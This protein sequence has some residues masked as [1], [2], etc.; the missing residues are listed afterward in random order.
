[1][2]NN[3]EENIEENLEEIEKQEET[4]EEEILEDI[5]EAEESGELVNSLKD[6]LLRLQAD[7]MNFKRRSEEQ[8]S[9]SMDYAKEKFA[10][11][12]LPCI[13]NFERALES[14]EEDKGSFYDGV[15]MIYEE[16]IKVLKKNNIEE[17]DALGEAFD[18]NMHHAVF[19]EESDNHDPET[20]IEI[21]QKGYKIKEKVIRPAMVKVSK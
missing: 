15:S 6:Q 16:L 5:E 21:L 9:S 7:F 2:S 20:V 13:D 4:I 3:V 14:G 10:L 1:M 18:P 12:I 8:R 11:D 19:A 17:I